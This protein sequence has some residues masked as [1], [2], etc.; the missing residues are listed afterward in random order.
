MKSPIARLEV[1]PRFMADLML[2]MDR[3]P[4]LRQRALPA[5]AAHPDLFSGLL[6]MHVGAAR[7]ADFAADCL[8]L[9]WRM[10]Y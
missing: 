8:A 9:G 3:W 7:T 2:S 6:A 4:K 5:L 10:L 1:R